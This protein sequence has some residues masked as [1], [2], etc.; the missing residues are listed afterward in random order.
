MS[1]TRLNTTTGVAI[2]HITWGIYA[3]HE[4][5]QVSKSAYLKENS[6]EQ[7][8]YQA[9]RSEWPLFEFFPEVIVTY[10]EYLYI[11]LLGFVLI[12]L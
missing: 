12:D 11:Y 10:K 6:S 4:T 7:K 5:F 8:G 9:K 1:D 2:N 3:I